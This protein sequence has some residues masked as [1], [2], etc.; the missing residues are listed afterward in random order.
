MRNQ[1]APICKCGCG[2]SVT[3]SKLYPHNWNKF[4]H[5]HNK[6]RLGIKHSEETTKKISKSLMGHPCT[7]NLRGKTWEE[8]YGIKEAKKR[9]K[10]LSKSLM[11]RT[12][13]EKTKEKIRLL[14]TGTH[15]S[16][17]TKEK[18]SKAKIG[19]V[20]S[21]EA[22]ANIK[23]AQT[24]K[25]QNPEYKE[26]QLKAIF[27]GLELRPTKPERKLRRGLNKLFPGEYKYVGDGTIFIGGKCP[28]FINVNGQKK[29]I[30]LFGDYWHSEKAT[31]I[32]IK[33]HEKQ[34]IKH[35]AKYGFKILIVWECELQNIKRLKKK[36]MEFHNGKT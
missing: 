10:E 20:F 16:K 9:Q 29:I 27:A 23:E 25:W 19:K 5:G 30:E 11:G 36:L 13:S 34:R 14:R 24:K 12:V 6:N 22:K 18:I 2:K 33:E 32:F 17:A 3:R 15:H 31:G 21:E 7:N 1:K 26:K 4:I 35:F 8:V 28:D